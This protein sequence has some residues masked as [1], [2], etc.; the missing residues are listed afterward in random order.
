MDKEKWHGALEV[1]EGLCYTKFF[2]LQ[3][4]NYD[5]NTFCL[6]CCYLSKGFLIFFVNNICYWSRPCQEVYYKSQ[7]TYGENKHK[8]INWYNKFI[9]VSFVS[10]V[11]MK[12]FF[13]FMTMILKNCMVNGITWQQ[14]KFC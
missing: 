6:M 12:H 11:N 14:N 1:A 10:M 9:D 8:I 5:E 7:I 4:E 3:V 2:F 13:D